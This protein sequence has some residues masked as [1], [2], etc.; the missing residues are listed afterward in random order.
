MYCPE[1]YLTLFEVVGALDVIASERQRCIPPRERPEHTDGR[2][3]RG[4]YIDTGEREETEAKA[5]SEWLFSLFMIGQWN[6]LYACSPA[7]ITLRLSREVTS[8]SRVYD[9]PF[10]EDEAGQQGL[11]DHLK[12][13]LNYVSNLTFLIAPHKTSMNLD[14]FAEDIIGGILVPLLGWPVCWKP[15][16]DDLTNEELHQICLAARDTDHKLGATI[17]EEMP[18]RKRGGQKHGGGM[19]EIAIHRQ[20][21][22]QSSLTKYAPDQKE[23]TLAEATAWAQEIFG[24]DVPRSTMQRYLAPIFEKMA[25]HK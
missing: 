12:Y 14:E 24:L 4:F 17:G 16:K 23:A 7:G 1:G 8:A 3:E 9:G 2:S 11:I 5:Y 18:K 13:G 15:P 19:V 20:F 25:A 21:S 10:P 6:N 22:K